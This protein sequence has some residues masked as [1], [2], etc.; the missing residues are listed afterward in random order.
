[1]GIAG[2]N[3]TKEASDMLLM[4]DNFASIVNGIE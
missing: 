3:I 4:D 1:M 2:S